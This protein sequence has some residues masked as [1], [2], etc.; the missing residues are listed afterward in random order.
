MMNSINQH[1]EAS[2]LFIFILSL[3]I[4]SLVLCACNEDDP[5]EDTSMSIH[6]FNYKGKS[7]VITPDVSRPKVTINGEDI[8]VA[9]NTKDNYS[10]TR[11]LPYASFSSLDELAKK[12]IDEE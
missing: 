1:S 6:E 4:F 3:L 12:V 2:R 9:I 11:H 7:I 8:P 5:V 10:A